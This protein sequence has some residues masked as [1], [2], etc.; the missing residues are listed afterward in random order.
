MRRK[1]KITSS[2]GVLKRKTP[3]RTCV[4]CRQV[5]DKRQLVRL[6]RTPEGN[7]EID[8]GGKMAGRG[9]YLCPDEEC[10]KTVLKG[11]Q[12]EHTLHG[13]ISRDKRE[14]LVRKGQDYIRGV[15]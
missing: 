14:E 9:A 3:L 13:S 5:R 1:K 12:L 10:W 6:V 8:T 2:D 11:N 4:G 15:N 7:I